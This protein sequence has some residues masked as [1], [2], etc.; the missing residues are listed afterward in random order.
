MNS[1]IKSL[2]ANGYITAGSRIIYMNL[3]YG[4]E[5]GRGVLKAGYH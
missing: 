4:E 1:V 2:T 3:T 5:R